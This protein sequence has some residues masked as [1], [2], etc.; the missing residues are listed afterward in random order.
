MKKVALLLS[1]MALF[2]C[3]GGSSSS[4]GVNLEGGGSTTPA[5]GLSVKLVDASAP[6]KAYKM[7]GM[8][9]GNTGA[10][11]SA[12][13][14]RVVARIIKTTYPIDTVYDSATDTEVPAINYD[15]ATHF[16]DS[17]GL[18]SAPYPNC[19][20]LS[21]VMLNNSCAPTGVPVTSLSATHHAAPGSTDYKKVIDQDYAG[22]TMTIYLPVNDGYTLD[23]ITS[24]YDSVTQKN[25][26]LTLGS[27]T[28]VNVTPTGGNATVTMNGFANLVS[29]NPVALTNTKTDLTQITSEEQYSLTVTANGQLKNSFTV[30]QSLTNT[31]IAA[32]SLVRANSGIPVS[33][34]APTSHVPGSLFFQGVFTLD[35]TMLKAGESA[36]NWTRVYP[37]PAYGESVSTDLLYL[38]GM[39]FP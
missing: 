16:I 26:L 37:N 17:T 6:A 4:G 27:I 12:N 11:P 36:T 28:G 19:G 10:Q 34:T 20:G 23:F 18:N 21:P 31:P 25:S 38:V 33:F 35:D 5:A 30:G 39:T 14:V 32:A 15:G 9:V 8:T 29:Y 22:G 1:A 24:A 2:G 7:L 13:K 3:G